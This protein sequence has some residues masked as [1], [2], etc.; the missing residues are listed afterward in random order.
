MRCPS[1]GHEICRL[2]LKCSCGYSVQENRELFSSLQRQWK[3]EAEWRQG[4][5]LGVS[6]AASVFVLE[7]LTDERIQASCLG[8]LILAPI[9]WA[10]LRSLYDGFVVA[11]WPTTI[12]TITAACVIKIQS[13]PGTEFY[14]IPK[15]VYETRY[16]ESVTGTKG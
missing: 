3:E 9:L 16:L 11:S 8:A 10:I 2:A 7:L 14:F 15:V 6:F 4:T 13:Q 1:C 5:V 12:G